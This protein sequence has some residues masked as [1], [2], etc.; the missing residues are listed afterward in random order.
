MRLNADMLYEAVCTLTHVTLLGTRKRERTLRF[1]C[2]DDGSMERLA[3]GGVYLTADGSRPWRRPAPADVL[4]VTWTQG[5]E[6]GEPCAPVL[7][8]HEEKDPMRILNLLQDVFSRLALWEEQLGDI[9]EHDSSVSRMIE[10]SEPFFHHPLCVVDT[11]MR[12]LGYSSSFMTRGRSALLPDKEG[13]E[14]GDAGGRGMLSA[15]ALFY[16]PKRDRIAKLSQQDLDLGTLYMIHSAKPFSGTEE[17]LFEFLSKK[18]C[19]ALQNLSMLT[20]LYSNSFK[21]QM[22][23]GFQ[24]GRLEGGRLYQGLQEWGGKRGDTFVCYKVKASYLNQK[25][26]AEYICGIFENAIPSS[27]AF[28]NDGVLVVLVDVTANGRPIETI[29]G[30][31]GTVLRQLQ[32]KAGVSLPF[33]DLPKAWYHFRQACCAFEEGY[34]RAAEETLYFFRTYVGDYMLR[35]AMGEFPEHFLM[36]QGMQRLIEHDRQYAVS[37]LDTLH[38]FF[39]CGMNMSQTAEQ[40]GI[41]RTSLNSRMKNIWECLDHRIDSRYLL[42]LQMVLAI[43]EEKR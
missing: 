20:G 27:I 39:R 22:E 16:D 11:S 38:A 9:L 32:L 25:I 37:Y 28:W 7:V 2:F 29:H 42:Y 12:Y 35:Q 41:H 5:P 1:P 21:A 18:L 33:T 14:T 34:P 31:M 26:N 23:S 40:L 30:E 36:D 24:T 8:F 43:L 3:A 6:T 10:V 19:H 15:A 13:G 17:V 4:W